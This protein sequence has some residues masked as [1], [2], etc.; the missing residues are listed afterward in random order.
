M[1]N[2]L[3]VGLGLLYQKNVLR[4]VY[5]FKIV[6]SHCNTSLSISAVAIMELDVADGACALTIANNSTHARF[7]NG[8]VGG[9]SA[10]R[11]GVVIYL[12]GRTAVFSTAD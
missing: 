11:S 8:S 10:Q 12:G 5:G 3:F 2:L 9:G 1:L 6:Q 4:N 7:I